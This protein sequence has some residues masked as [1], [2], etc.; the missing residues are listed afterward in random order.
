AG[1]RG[2]GG[3]GGDVAQREVEVAGGCPDRGRGP[4][5]LVEEVA[6]E[7]APDGE[8][9]GLPLP[10]VLHAGQPAVVQ[11]VAE[12]QRE[13]EVLVV[14][15]RWQGADVAH[16]AAQGGEQGLGELTAR[17]HGARLPARRGR[18]AR[19]QLGGEGPQAA[20][21]GD[22]AV[23]VGGAAGRDDGPRARE[24]ARTAQA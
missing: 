11:L 16:G 4:A 7:L 22:R 6:L 9:R 19:G 24:A 14:A 17:L 23:L 20:R 10:F 8:Q 21:G 13:L 2:A 3:G 12:V 15:R 18:K 5:D 1:Q